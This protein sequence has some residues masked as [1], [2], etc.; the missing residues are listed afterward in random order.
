MRAEN[1][2]RILPSLQKKHASCVSPIMV[3]L[4]TSNKMFNELPRLIGGR[5]F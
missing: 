2:H 4:Y 1:L 3:W 5:G